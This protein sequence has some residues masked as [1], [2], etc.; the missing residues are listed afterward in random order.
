[1]VC[2]V[3]V[4]YVIVTFLCGYSGNAAVVHLVLASGHEWET[5]MWQSEYCYCL[6][7]ECNVC[8]FTLKRSLY[9]SHPRLVMNDIFQVI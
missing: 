2:I 3:F 7:K 8:L 5:C 9:T 4:N 6:Y 1:V